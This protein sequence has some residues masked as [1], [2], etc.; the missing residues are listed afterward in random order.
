M[1]AGRYRSIAVSCNVRVDHLREWYKE[2]KFPPF[3]TKTETARNPYHRAFGSIMGIL[4]YQQSKLGIGEP[5]DFFFDTEDEELNALAGWRYFKASHPELRGVTGEGP[6]FRNDK[7]VLPLQ[8]AD[9][10]AWWT[11]ERVLQDKNPAMHKLPWGEKR[12]LY[13]MHIQLARDRFER[14]HKQMLD[15]AKAR[16]AR[17]PYLHLR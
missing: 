6:A 4:M 17:L 12:E 1:T 8:A 5:A 15:P 13:K 16:L 10:Y 9:L 11:R 14:E 2:A 7:K 3:I